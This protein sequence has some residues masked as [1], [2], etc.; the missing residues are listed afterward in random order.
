LKKAKNVI[1]FKRSSRVLIVFE[2]DIIILDAN[3]NT[4]YDILRDFS[5][6][7]NQIADAKLN[8]NE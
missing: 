4:G 1:A 3:V 2:N 7:I 8:L 5:L 6:R